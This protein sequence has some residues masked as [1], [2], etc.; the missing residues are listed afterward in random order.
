MIRLAIDASTPVC[1]V[2]LVLDSNPKSFSRWEK[3][4]GVHSSRLF[5]QINEVLAEAGITL[6]QVDEFVISSGPGSYTGLRIAAS[7]LKGILYATS[8]QI[9]AVQTLAFFASA[10]LEIYPKAKRIHA[11]IDAR[12]THLYHQ[13]FEFENG[14]LTSHNKLEIRDLEE[15]NNLI[16]PE[17]FIGGT[18]F[19][20]LDSERLQKLK[21]T[22][23]DERETINPSY[24]ALFS[25]KNESWKSFYSKVTP[26]LFEP[27]YYTY[28]QA[29]VHQPVTPKTK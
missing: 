21:C 1:C 18:G 17:D 7:A 15:I 25:T 2:G 10:I 23:V 5:E 16:K 13:L 19:E 24:L 27:N 3:G 26:A 9:T 22:L 20:R 4:Q 29:Q 11:V 6:N 28:G 8:K 14:V 12:R